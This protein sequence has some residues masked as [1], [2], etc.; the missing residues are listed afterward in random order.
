MDDFKK[1]WSE[2]DSSFDGPEITRMQLELKSRVDNPLS[3]L[4]SNFRLNLFLC[5]ICSLI[6][7]TIFILMDGFWVRLLIGIILIGY[8][9]AIW[10]TTFLYKRYLKNLFPDENIYSYLKNLNKTIQE[11]LWYQEIIAIFFYPVCLAA[12][13]FLSLYER[14]EADNFFTDPAIWGSLAVVIVILTP[15]LYLLAKWL[16]KISFRKYLNNIEEILNEIEQAGEI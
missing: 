9:G 8:A 2:I 15:L 16:N 6:M 7:A 4:K 1:L 12:G 11:G 5:L 10:H 14:G 13:Y 3:K